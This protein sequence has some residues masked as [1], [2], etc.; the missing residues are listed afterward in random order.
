M[1]D[2]D[3]R[4]AGVVTNWQ[5]LVEEEK[6]YSD[7]SEEWVFRGDSVDRPLQ[8]TLER[9]KTTAPGISTRKLESELFSAFKRSFRI[10]TSQESRP[11][12]DVLYWLSLMRH[13]GTPTRLLDFTY[14]LFIATFF[15]LERQERAEAVVWLISKT[16]LTRPNVKSMF[17]KG[18]DINGK[19]I[20]GPDF[21]KLWGNRDAAAFRAIFW[22]QNTRY[23]G[24][25]PVNPAASHQRLHLQQG[26]FLCPVDVEKSFS[27]N[28][29]D[30]NDQ[31]REKVLRL[32]IK[33]E[34]RDEIL[35]KLHRA[36]T[37]RELLFPGLDGF[38]QGL[39]SRT[40]IIYSNLEELGKS[41]ARVATDDN[42]EFRWSEY[43]DK[44]CK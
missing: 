10:H 31:Y 25:F 1:D 30:V 24:V 39:Q 44:Y 18:A 23:Q 11:D 21:C 20:T 26:L 13:F 4:S 36:G 9:V 19:S 22:D 7:T 40:P 16:W 28:L 14:S 38:A 41:G 42:G 5:D 12:D 6:K 29:R 2:K 3:F 15:A 37:N 27:D 8:S 17:E 35:L 32:L 33:R 43:Y 34:C